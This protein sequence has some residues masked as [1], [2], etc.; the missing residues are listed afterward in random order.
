MIHLAQSNYRLEIVGKD[1]VYPTL[2][3]VFFGNRGTGKTTIAKLY[4]CILKGL[5]FLSDGNWELKQPKER[6][7][8]EV[9][10]V[11]HNKRHHHY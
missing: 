4:G 3:R 1:P 7:S 11:K 9:Y 8:L 10:L 6:I 2:N 5:G